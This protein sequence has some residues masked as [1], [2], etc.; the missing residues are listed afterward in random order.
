MARQSKTRLQQL[1]KSRSQERAASTPPP[2]GM[3]RKGSISA[4]DDLAVSWPSFVLISGFL[5]L[6]LF[7]AAVFFGSRGIEEGLEL[8]AANVLG[9]N[10]WMGVEVSAA[11]ADIALTGTYYEDESAEDIVAAVATVPGVRNVRANQLYA[12]ERPQEA[13][14]SAPVGDVVNVFWDADTI[15]ITGDVSDST[16]RTRLLSALVESGGERTV[17]AD[18]LSTVEGLPSE[19]EWIDEMSLLI[20]LAIPGI[21]EGFFFMNPAGEIFQVSGETESRQLARDINEAA[22]EIVIAFGFAYTDGVTVPE[23][24]VTREEV[25]ELQTNLDDLIEGK[26]VEFEY[27]S[28]ELTGVGTTLLDEI[29]AALRQFPK[30]PIRIDGHT[31]SDGTAERNLLLSILR[32]EAARE[33]LVARGADR[34]R[35]TV[36]GFGDTRP[37]GSNDTEEG[38]ARNRRIEFIAELE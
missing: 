28:A 12:I 25:I 21:P 9:N 35:F 33:Y 37:V 38:R 31:D 23:P 34:N 11:G 4:T 13:E 5:V 7:A 16:V 2:P 3:S 10:G 30:V 20:A 32:A 29:L 1:G 22:D 15:T 27:G 19:A 14:V 24:E 8:N 18:G 26:V 6:I 17:V 36:E